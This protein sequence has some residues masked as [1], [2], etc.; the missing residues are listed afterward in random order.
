MSTI[1][2]QLTEAPS[3]SKMTG[4]NWI[5]VEYAEGYY[6]AAVSDKNTTIETEDDTITVEGEWALRRATRADRGR[7]TKSY[8][9]TGDPAHS[10][11]FVAAYGYLEA[12]IT[13][14]VES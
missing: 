5:G 9:V 11:T 1:T 7:I 2:I 10:V 14:V 6:A 13:G 8:K 4:P 12:L 3:R